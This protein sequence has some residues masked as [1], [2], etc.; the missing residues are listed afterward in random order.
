MRKED[1]IRRLVKSACKPAVMPPE[2]KKRL[3]ERLWLE[4]FNKLLLEHLATKGKAG[5]GDRQTENQ[6]L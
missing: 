4:A 1:E 2:F 3:G 6:G 5:E